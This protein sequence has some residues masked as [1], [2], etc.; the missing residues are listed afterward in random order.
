MVYKLQLEEQSTADLKPWQHFAISVIFIATGIICSVAGSQSFKPWAVVIA[1]T[2]V[3]IFYITQARK[4][5]F[6]AFK[7]RFPILCIEWLVLFST[8]MYFFMIHYKLLYLVYGVIS[9]IVLVTGL[10]CFIRNKYARILISDKGIAFQY[11]KKV[12]WR[13]VADIRLGQDLLVINTVDKRSF[14]LKVA[15]VNFDLPAFHEF[16]SGQIFDKKFQS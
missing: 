12:S 10:M 7:V 9:S 14:T 2:G 16:C 1:L 4:E 15:G 6:S 11:D 3:S 8:A 5:L 13:E